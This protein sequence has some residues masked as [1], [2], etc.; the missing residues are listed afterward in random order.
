MFTAGEAAAVALG[1][2]AARRLGLEA[3]DALAKVRR[4]LP[5]RVRL[6]VES[7]EQTLGFTGE[8]ETA[9]PDGE[10]L[11]AIAEAASRGRRVLAKYTD[12]PGDDDRPRAEPVRPRRPQRPL[13]RPRLR[14]RPRRAAH[15]ARRPLRHRP[16]RRPGASPAPDG[17]DAIAFVTRTL[18][19]VPWAHEIEVLLHTDLGHRRAP[20]PAHAR[21]ARTAPEAPSCASAP[22]R[23]T[24]PPACSPPRAARSRPPRPPSCARDCGGRSPSD[25]KP[26]RPGS[27]SSSVGTTS[28][29]WTV[30]GNGPP[31]SRLSLISCVVS[32]APQTEQVRAMVS[33]MVR[34]SRSMNS[35]TVARSR[36]RVSPIIPAGRKPVP[37][38]SQYARWKSLRTGAS[39]MIA[40]STEMP[41]TAP[42]W[43][44]RG[45]DR[46][47]RWQSAP[48]GAHHRRGARERRERQADARSRS[49]AWPGGTRVT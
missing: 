4:V 16:P 1:L 43:R 36:R 14:P 23:S 33:S 12:S 9:P 37:A 28:I 35:T 41:S 46:R 42:S 30:H 31:S 7:L 13:V 22:T 38:I 8:L 49:R 47:C 10:T 25:C 27:D 18:A 6:G 24:G 2:M 45:G 40:I 17:F 26:P 21:R 39:P 11:L 34:S 19:R 20:L 48:A 3:D 44:E 29:A 32:F 15:P 5:D